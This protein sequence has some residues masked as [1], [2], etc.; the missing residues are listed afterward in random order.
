MRQHSPSDERR[1]VAAA[2]AI[3]TAWGERGLRYAVVHGLEPYPAGLGRD[4]DVVMRR[5]TVRPAVRLAL[6]LGREHG[7][8]QALFRWSHW[9]LYQLALLDPAKSIALPIDLLC[10]THVWRAKWVRLVDEPLLE[11]LVSGDGRVGPF[12]V[13]NEGRFLKS[14]VRPLLCGDFSR[15]G[16]GGEWGPA[17]SV[18]S[19]VDRRLLVDLLGPD[20]VAALESD[21]GPHS[22]RPSLAPPL[23]RRWIRAH[24]AGAVRSLG[25]AAIGRLLR[26]TLDPAA[27]LFV[28]AT[29]SQRVP[30]A[31]QSLA[32]EAKRLFIEVRTAASPRRPLARALAELTAWRSP[33]I[34]EFVVSVVVDEQPTGLGRRRPARPGWLP[35]GYLDLPEQIAAGEVRRELRAR[36][37]RLLTE[38]YSP[39]DFVAEPGQRPRVSC[40]PARS[41]VNGRSRS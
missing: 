17:L 16:R 21:E 5:E 22:L 1:R 3:A 37:L 19:R 26:R 12:V 11:G 10:S 8:D 32:P 40:E 33:P 2:E 31:A 27:C 15:F 6:A 39:D 14:F 30:E 36:V 20:R 38:T 18:P 29:R 9:G 23:Q 28:R 7:F 13:S 4:L 41:A 24:P 34:S 35:T 25:D